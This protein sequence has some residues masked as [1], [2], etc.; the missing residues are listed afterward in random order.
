MCDLPL[1]ITSH[2]Q[3]TPGEFTISGWEIDRQLDTLIGGLDPSA[4]PFEILSNADDIISPDTA[5]ISDTAA[6]ADDQIGAGMLNSI[7]S[8][9]K[10]SASA[11]GRFGGLSGNGL[12]GGGGS[13][14][15]ARQNFQGRGSKS[16]AGGILRANQDVWVQDGGGIPSEQAL[17]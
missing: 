9:S 12:N 14:K 5:A 17:R 7:S 4:D 16:M 1:G 8:I 13:F 15:P 2:L 3:I 10:G 6:T 11:T